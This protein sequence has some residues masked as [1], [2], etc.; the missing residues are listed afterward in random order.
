MPWVFQVINEII[1]VLQAEDL[2]CMQLFDSIIL[3]ACSKF[4]AKAPRLALKNV[5]NKQ[6][7]KHLLHR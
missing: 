3:D 4:L 5:A 7:I 1:I 6:N 2:S